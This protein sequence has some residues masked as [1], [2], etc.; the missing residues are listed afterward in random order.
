MSSPPGQH[1]SEL[2]GR[3]FEN[4]ALSAGLIINI[5]VPKNRAK[6]TTYVRGVTNIGCLGVVTRVREPTNIGFIFGG[7]ILLLIY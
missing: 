1:R 4:S 5:C 7:S 2:L 3:L 6:K